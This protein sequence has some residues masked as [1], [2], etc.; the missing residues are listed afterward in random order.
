MENE[1]W[2][3]QNRT[4]ELIAKGYYYACWTAVTCCGIIPLIFLAYEYF[5]GLGVHLRLPFEVE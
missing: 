2:L 3:S 1:Q 5:N 4:G